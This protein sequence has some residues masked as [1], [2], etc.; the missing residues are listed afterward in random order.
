MGVY[1]FVSNGIGLMVTFAFPFAL[2]AIGWKTYMINGTWD[3]FELA[4]VM[5]YWVETKGRTLE[6]IDEIF[7]GELHSDVPMMKT[8][9]GVD[10][11][12]RENIVKSVVLTK[13]DDFGRVAR[14][15]DA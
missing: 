1:T 2:E 14:H 4:F 7:D 13:A 6:E 12:E 11:A 5:L 10:P 3:I 15:E 8:I 9:L